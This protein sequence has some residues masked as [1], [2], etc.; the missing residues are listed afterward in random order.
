MRGECF[1]EDPPFIKAQGGK[2]GD[3][4]GGADS[5]LATALPL[6]PFFAY[7]CWNGLAVLHAAPFFR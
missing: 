3:G 4:G 5:E 7:C 1:L 2:S 6:A